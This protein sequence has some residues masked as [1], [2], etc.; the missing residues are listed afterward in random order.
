MTVPL[1]TL[2]DYLTI[3][4]VQGGK[5]SGRTVALVVVRHGS[6]T[7]LLE[8]QTGLGAVQCLHLALLVTAK[9]QCVLG[10]TQVEPHDLVPSFTV[11]YTRCS[12]L[13]RGCSRGRSACRGVNW[14][15]QMNHEQTH[16][17]RF[18]LPWLMNC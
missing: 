6:G 8:R 5:Q 11:Y 14:L 13:L 17:R 7:P 12:S 2:G 18:E 15:F 4:D 9:H 10:R 3:E 16:T 1:L